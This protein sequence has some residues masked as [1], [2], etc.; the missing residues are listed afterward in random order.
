MGA[1]LRPGYLLAGIIIGPFLLGLVGEQKDVMH[2]AEFG[3]VLMLFL[4][5][6]ELRPALL[7]QLKGPILGTGGLQVL[8][9]SVALTGVGYLWVCPGSRGSPSVSFLRSPP[10]PSCCRA[11]R[12]AN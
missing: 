9:T 7:W 5:G 12:S 10:P 11:C 4:V 1:G 6:L 3:V 2:F 8:L